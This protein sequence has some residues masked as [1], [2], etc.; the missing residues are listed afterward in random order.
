M[1]SR[2]ASLSGL[3]TVMLA[4]SQAKAALNGSPAVFAPK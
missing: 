4:Q 3:F 2:G 1:I